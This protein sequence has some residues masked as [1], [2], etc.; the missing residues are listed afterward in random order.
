MKCECTGLFYTE[1]FPDA[2]E[3]F[4]RVEFLYETRLTAEIIFN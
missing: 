4:P 3:Q 1:P 2:T